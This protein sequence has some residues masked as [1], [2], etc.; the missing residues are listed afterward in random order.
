MSYLHIFSTFG[1][2]IKTDLNKNMGENT[3]KAFGTEKC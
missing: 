3:E 2:F 1:N